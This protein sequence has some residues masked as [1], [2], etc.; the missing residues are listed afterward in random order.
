MI[1]TPGIAVSQI[2]TSTTEVVVLL[3]SLTTRGLASHNHDVL[4]PITRYGRIGTSFQYELAPR[5]ST[6]LQQFS[7]AFSESSVELM[8]S[9]FHLIYVGPVTR[10]RVMG[11]GFARSMSNSS[12]Q[13]NDLSG[14]KDR[15]D[16]Q[17]YHTRIV[18]LVR[19]WCRRVSY[20]SKYSYVQGTCCR[21][22]G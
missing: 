16:N 12:E 17:S 5:T 1:Y 3:L 4:G 15:K 2:Y 19:R 14:E 21:L 7:F 22:S 6:D 11:A 13:R 10:Q 20:I 8:F 18:V 9:C